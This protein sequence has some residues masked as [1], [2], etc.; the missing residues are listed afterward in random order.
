MSQRSDQ[1]W[2]TDKAA[3]RGLPQSQTFP[4]DWRT[5]AEPDGSAEYRGGSI[6]WTPSPSALRALAM[7]T[8]APGEECRAMLAGVDADAARA[9]LTSAGSVRAAVHMLTRPA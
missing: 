2:A 5:G 6:G 3:A 8:D 9:A 7:A 1:F 4:G